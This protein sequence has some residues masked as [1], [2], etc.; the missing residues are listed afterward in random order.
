MRMPLVHRDDEKHQMH[1]GELT[2]VGWITNVTPAGR[3]AFS[4]TFPYAARQLY[5]TKMPIRIYQR[6]MKSETIPHNPR[7]LFCIQD[8][9][10]QF[11]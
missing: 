9:M 8:A 3:H 4:H 1:F 7:I 6:I 5:Y 2:L 10:P 11:F